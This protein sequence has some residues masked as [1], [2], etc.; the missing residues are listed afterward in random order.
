MKVNIKLVKIEQ[1]E[2]LKKMLDV[3]KRE[4]AGSDSPV[5]YKYLDLYWERESRKPFFIIVDG[6]ISGFILINKHTLL[7]KEG[8]NVAEFYVEK[9]LRDNGVG[10][11]AAYKLFSLIPG[12]WEVRQLDNN[13]GARLFWNKIIKDYT[14]NN[15]QEIWLDN[16]DWHGSVQTFNTLVN[17]TR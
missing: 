13:K 5:E 2:I 1:K 4:L 16:S 3:Y 11:N 17:T 15:Y 9:K 6:H 14:N 12:K 10:K 7:Q 8:Y